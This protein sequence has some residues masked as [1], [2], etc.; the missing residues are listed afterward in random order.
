METEPSDSLVQRIGREVRSIQLLATDLLYLIISKL[1]HV[2][3]KIVQQIQ[4]SALHKL[5]FCL[6]QKNLDLQQ[7][8]LHLLHACL[9][10]TCTSIT[11]KEKGP[12]HQKRGSV[13][14]IS[15][16]ALTNQAND[17]L[18]LMQTSSELFVKCC[19]D[20]F[21]MSSNRTMLQHW[22]DF[23]LATLPYI[24]HGF[25]SIIV[26][27]LMCLCHQIN[28]RC[29][30]IEIV[31]HEKPQTSS[32]CASAEREVIILLMGLEKMMLFCLTER[33]LT[34]ND[35]WTGQDLPMPRIPE[36]SALVGLAQII[37]HDEDDLKPRDIMMFHLPVVLQILANAWRAFRKP[38][39]SDLAI[40]S[41][42]EAKQDAIMG[43]FL[44]AA[45]EAKDKLRN[46][47]ERL[48]KFSAVDFIEGLT[49]IFYMGNPT[50]LEFDQSE[51]MEDVALQI[52]SHT[53]SSSPQY[54]ISVL[55]D[56]IRQRTPGTYQNKR[57]K[58]LRHGKL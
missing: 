18:I 57:R 29:D 3:M 6:D 40:E 2:P 39:W 34:M 28:L 37:T 12:G 56:S 43:S 45:E 31:I 4:T 5:L 11:N 8:L 44:F 54:V 33:M 41:M 10:I 7:K 16:V 24:R 52:L 20:A 58:I 55:L 32:S 53:P 9:V 35:D 36:H 25:R 38:T 48:F 21:S 51:A 49:E 15:S 19:I 13:D 23:V 14:S 47:F 1:D 42:G 30:T 27:L 22:M 26:P 50:A 46:F 17:A